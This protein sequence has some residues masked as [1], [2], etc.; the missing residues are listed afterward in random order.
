[1]AGEQEPRTL[2]ML[3][4]VSTP[5][6]GKLALWAQAAP[7]TLQSGAGGLGGLCSPE[8]GLCLGPQGTPSV[9]HGACPERAELL[10]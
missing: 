10:G 2:S 6:G 1:M 4:A 9:V 8:A 3:S 7:V 5:A